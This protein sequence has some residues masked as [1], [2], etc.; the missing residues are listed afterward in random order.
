M[1]VH[2]KAKAPLARRCRC[3]YRFDAEGQELVV[4]G[5]ELAALTADPM[6]VVTVLEAPEARN[7]LAAPPA[8][9][10]LGAPEEPD[11]PAPEGDAPE[12]EDPEGEAHA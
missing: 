2:V 11:N 12:G 9:G 7:A 4:S 1:I 10:E 3:G 5:K 6:L 8:D